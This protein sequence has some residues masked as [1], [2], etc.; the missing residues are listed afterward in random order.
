VRIDPTPATGL[1]KISTA[2]VLQLR[3]VDVQRL[4]SRV[5]ELSAILMDDIA[6]AIAIVV[7]HR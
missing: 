5:G 3:G 4:V 2:D 1:H 6:A 7:E